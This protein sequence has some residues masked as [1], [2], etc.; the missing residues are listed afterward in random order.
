MEVALNFLG[1]ERKRA[2]YSDQELAEAVNKISVIL[3]KWEAAEG[4]DSSSAVVGRMLKGMKMVLSGK[5]MVA[6]MAEEIEMGI[7]GSDTANSF[8]RSSKKVI[9]QNIYY[10]IVDNGL[11]KFG[12]DSATG[13]R[14]ARH[15]G[16]V[17]VSSNPVIA[18]RAFDEIADLW[19]RFG[20]VAATH[21][22]WNQ[23]KERYAD[24]VAL[25]R[26]RD[27]PSPEYLGFS[28]DS[29]PV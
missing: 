23:N 25:Y 8:I 6:K 5:G 29:T 9:E 18:A 24:E 16:A 3:Q 15:L 13:L 19:N 12:N 1:M 28:A 17:Q 4:S 10:R 2:G 26:Y 27:I 21:P 20:I 7:V 22:E 11:S 14:W